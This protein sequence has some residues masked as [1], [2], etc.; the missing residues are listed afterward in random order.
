[1]LKKNPQLL[2]LLSL[3]LENL[4]ARLLFNDPLR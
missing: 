3:D 1:M 4:N 2:N